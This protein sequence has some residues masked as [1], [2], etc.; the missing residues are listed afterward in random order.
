MGLTP[1]FLPLL[2]LTDRHQ[3]A[4]LGLVDTVAAAVDGGARTVVLREK[5]LS[6][7]AREDLAQRLARLLA[8]AGGTLLVA[9]PDVALARAV[10]AS[11]IH[12]SATDPCPDD[13]SDL[14]VGRSCHDRDEVQAAAAEGADY[15]TISPVAATSSKPGYGPALGLAGLAK[16]TSATELPLVALGGVTEA[17]AGDCLAAGAVGVA[18]MGAVMASDHPAQVVSRLVVSLCGATTGPGRR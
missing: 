13:T 7:R 17:S 2:V 14:V 11:G 12:L 4:R 18:V 5:D 16:L 10:G 8:P 6:R 3:A 15:A 9:G 1:P